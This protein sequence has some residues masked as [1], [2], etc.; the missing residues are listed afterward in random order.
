[1]HSRR[2]LSSRPLPLNNHRS[3]QKDDTNDDATAND[4][5]YAN[6]A[7]MEKI[8]RGENVAYRPGG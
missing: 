5:K 3:N 7:K 2:C 6:D 1:M 4:R 8:L